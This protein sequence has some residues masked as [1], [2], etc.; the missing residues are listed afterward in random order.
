VDGLLVVE[1]VELQQLAVQAATVEGAQV[2]LLQPMHLLELMQLV[3]A[4]VVVA[5]LK[6][7]DK[8]VPES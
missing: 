4:A 3:L 2:A 5:E 6:M 8:V 1:E 7:V